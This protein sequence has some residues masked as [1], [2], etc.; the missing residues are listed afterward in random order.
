MTGP[1]WLHIALFSVF[2]VGSLLLFRNPLLR[3]LDISGGAVDLD[4]LL[5]EIGTAIDDIEPG[6]I[7]R[8]ELR[9]AMWTA[10]NT[11]TVPIARGHRSIVVER[12]RLTLF[13]RSEEAA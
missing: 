1:L 13:I 7:G 9:G 8:L 5:G 6:A 3:M 12:D 2:S 10:R 11:G 4:N